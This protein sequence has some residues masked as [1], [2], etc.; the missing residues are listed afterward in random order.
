MPVRVLAVTH[1]ANVG[2]GVFADAVRAAGHELATWCVPLGGAPPPTADAILVFGGAMHPDEDERHRWLRRE[3]EFLGEHLERRTPLLGVC[4]GA[5]LIAKAAGAA[6]FPAPASE[7]GW[8]PVERLADD[9]V[10]DVLPRRFDAFQWHHYTYE[11]PEGATVLARSA[12]ATQAFRLGQALGIQFHAE[13]TAETVESWLADEPDDV[14]DTVA[15][16]RETA[17][18]IDGWNRLGRALC[19]R[20][21][22]LAYPVSAGS[23]SSR[24]HSCHDPT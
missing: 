20:F 2:A 11:V 9:P 1:G 22:E 14:A 6:V 8:L 12:V 21:L 18:R 4:L 17:A 7:V 24:D 10:L 15:F 23:A 19:G 3:H 13:V 16:R 5:Q